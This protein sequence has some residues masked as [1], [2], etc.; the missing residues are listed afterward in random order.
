[1]VR[2]HHEGVQRVSCFVGL[3]TIHLLVIVT[4]DDW[5][6]RSQP[7][8]PPSQG[9]GTVRRQSISLK[10]CQVL[11]YT[12]KASEGFAVGCVVLF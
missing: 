6:M 7:S 9:R 3:S 1:M 10:Q 2:R 12:N 8:F 11:S 4:T 5:P